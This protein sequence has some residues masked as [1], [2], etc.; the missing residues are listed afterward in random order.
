MVV[1]LERA[2]MKPDFPLL[3]QRVESNVLDES[4]MH[5]ADVILITAHQ[6]KGL[7]WDR[8]HVF[9]DFK[10]EYSVRNRLQKVK[11]WREEACVLY[12]ALTRARKELLIQHPLRQWIAGDRGWQKTY[13]QLNPETCQF[14]ETDANASQSELQRARR[15][16]DII[17]NTYSLIPPGGFTGNGDLWVHGNPSQ[18][19]GLLGYQPGVAHRETLCLYCASAMVAAE[20]FPETGDYVRALALRISENERKEEEKHDEVVVWCERSPWVEVWSAWVGAERE[21]VELW[22]GGVWERWQRDEDD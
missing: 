6:A 19:R 22:T 17:I 11:H 18:L 15:L 4:E 10:P 16:S 5:L 9:A 3:L 2:I 7:E 8:V 1:Q 12:V 14:F 13:L 21:R 20:D